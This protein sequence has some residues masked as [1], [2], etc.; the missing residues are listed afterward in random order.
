MNVPRLSRIGIVGAGRGGSALLDLFSE[1]PHVTVAI[2]VDLDPRA[3]GLQR[4]QARGIP[5][6]TD[7]RT[8][9]A[10]AVDVVIEV[11]GRP[12]VQADLLRLK[13]LDVEILGASSARL[14]WEILA[15]TQQTLAEVS[16]LHSVTKAVGQSLDLADVQ[17]AAL[18]AAME[19]TQTRTGVI[20]LL[21]EETGELVIT[22]HR[23]VSKSFIQRF[24]RLPL[25]ES[26]AAQALQERGATVSRVEDYPEG[27]PLRAALLDDGIKV[28][29]TTP[30]RSRDRVVG[31][32][33]VSDPPA[34]TFF[35]SQLILLQAMGQ[36]IGLAIDNARVHNRLTQAFEE[37][38]AT[39]EHLVWSER[40]TAL[41][42]MASGVAHDFNNRLAVIL[43]R[44]Q[45]LLMKT[46]DPNLIR[47]LQLIE[48]TALKSA[49]TVRRVLEF[50]RRRRDQPSSPVHMTDLIEEVV[51]GTR[52]KWKDEAQAHGVTISLETA[53]EPV[54]PILGHAPELREVLTNL[55]FNSV[56]AMP[57]GG[58]I[59]LR[60][61]SAGNQV[62]IEVEDTGFG[63]SEAI[64]ARA[65][66]PFFTTKS[67]GAGLG[68]SVAYG[69]ISRHGGQIQVASREGRGTTV[70]ILLPVAGEAASVP[71]RSSGTPGIGPPARI[72]VIDDEE[73][74]RVALTEIL[75]TH[76]HLVTEAGSGPEG[77]ALLEATHFDLVF[78]DLGMPGMTGWEVARRVKTLRPET[79]VVLITGWGPAVDPHELQKKSVE[80]ILFKPFRMEELLD[81]VQAL[82]KGSSRPPPTI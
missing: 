39:Q 65:F 6:S 62:Q 25:R 76:S 13:P 45:L 63:M 52:G 12:E 23:G 68:L 78:T 21:S 60:T 8:V 66:E 54:P 29:A 31:F 72:L 10:H 4:A 37:L 38:K 49:E 19:V 17:E 53:L 58:R 55:I 34:S 71:S 1:A 20:R 36:Q 61:R 14:M 82:V 40:L 48:Q 77:L 56:E 75:A 28:V 50:T 64:Q 79:P 44:T 41:G 73:P 69:I 2:V 46:D 27:S 15:K 16:A 51:E 74:V 67:K 3:P 80:R 57:L 32:L 9:F 42:E 7:L 70:T 43:G 30:L 5:T 26:P 22:A 24:E 59:V 11:T 18:A 33:A 81:T 35:P 47:D